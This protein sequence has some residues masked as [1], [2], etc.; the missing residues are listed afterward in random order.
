MP[1]ICCSIVSVFD[2]TE[3]L[4][5]GFVHITRAHATEHTFMKLEQG[6]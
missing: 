2:A 1:A 6:N 3:C 4:F 5:S